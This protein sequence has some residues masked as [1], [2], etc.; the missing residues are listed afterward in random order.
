MKKLYAILPCYNEE[1]N[2]GKLIEEWEKQK[3]KLG[4]TGYELKII[5]INDASTDK[6]KEEILK[7]KQKNDNVELVEHEQNKGL[8]GG[9][10]TAIHYFLKNGTK[11]DLLTLMDGDNTHNPK[12]IHEMLEKIKEGSTCVIA[13]RYREKSKIVGL[14]KKR[15]MMS[16]FAKIYYSAILNIPNVKDYTCGYRTYTYE[17]IEKMIKKFGENPIKE[18]SFACMMELL[19]KVYKVGAKFEEVGFELRYDQK[20]GESKMNVTK[21]AQRSLITAIK[22][23]F[24]Y[25]IASMLTLILIIVFAIFLSLGTNFSPTSNLMIS[26]DCGIFSYVGYAMSQGR[27]LYREVWENKGPLL[28]IIY[29]LGQIINA[30]RGVYVMEFLSI[31]ISTLFA[32]KTIKIITQ[33]RIYS[34]LG[35]IYTFSAWAIIYEGGT[36]SENFALPIIMIRSIPIHK[37]NT[38]KRKNKQFKYNNM[39][40]INSY[41]CHAKTK[42]VVNIF[43]ILHNHRDS[44]NKR[45]RIQRNI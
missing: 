11:D 36:F 26:H 23:K 16:N 25:D 34:I 4:K 24:R 29:Y 22:L 8:C 2:I 35:L 15:E 12:Y 9:L 7:Q 1:E 31:F 38:T 39:G 19:Y 5:A 14:E 18:K 6:T 45:K 41:N 33:K 28:Y 30:D 40:N 10:N 44:I 20:G 13:S 17:I 3:E 37:A 27:A 43:G 42:H 32:Y 21:T